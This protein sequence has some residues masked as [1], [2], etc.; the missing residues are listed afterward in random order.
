[1]TNSSIFALATT[2]LLGW[3]SV[4][5]GQTAAPPPEGA[6]A[7]QGQQLVEAAIRRSAAHATVS[8]KLRIR[9]R[10]MEQLLVG[11][12]E[13]AQLRS[14]NGL[15]LRL[16][17]SIQAGGKAT[18][19]KQVCDGRDLWM[20]WRLGDAEQLQHV[21]L[22]RVERELADA[23]SALQARNP[24][25]TL[26]T[27][28]LPKLLTQLA[29]NFDFGRAA[30]EA[31][32]LSN[33]AIWTAVGAWKPERLA[34]LVPEACTDGKPHL[35]RLPDQLPHQIT[36]RFGQ[37]DLFPYQLVFERWRVHGEQRELVPMVIVEFYEVLLGGEL[38]PRQFDYRPQQ[39]N[40]V[41]RTESFLQTLGLPDAKG[42]GSERNAKAQRPGR[43]R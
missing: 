5:L 29:E 33:V 26:A 38:D 30:P 25:A 4:A 15:L 8:A 34:A 20:H 37:S 21:D 11:S 27:G 7:G 31:G 41:D 36:I 6:K 10:L 1:M 16:E 22:A 32:E 12:G 28:G 9:T 18:S 35:D 42:R 3:N 19:V 14:S 40:V 17:L 43:V 2:A 24:T 23:P 13:Y 39:L